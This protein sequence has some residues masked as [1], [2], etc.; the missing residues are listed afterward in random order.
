MPERRNMGPAQAIPDSTMRTHRVRG[1]GKTLQR[2]PAVSEPSPQST[3]IGRRAIGSKRQPVERARKGYP[4]IVNG[5]VCFGR[6][7]FK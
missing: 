4:F 6:T 3:L 5:Q 1:P 2:M 7:R